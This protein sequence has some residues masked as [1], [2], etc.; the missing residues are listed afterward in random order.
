MALKVIGAG[1]GRTGTSSLKLA[2]EQLGFGKCYHATEVLQNPSCLPKW[3]AVLEGKPDWDDLFEGYQSSVDWPTAA[4]YKAQMSKYPEAKVI[5]TV[6]DADSW[7]RSVSET[8]YPLSRLM[9]PIWLGWLSERARQMRRLF[10]DA[11]WDG[12][13]HGR[14]EDKA[15]ATRIFNEHIE[16]VKREVRP[17]R[18]LV[19]DVREGWAPLCEFLEIP[20]IPDEPFP[21]VN[22]GAVLKG[23]LRRL[24]LLFGALYAVVALLLL[25]GV[26]A[27]FGLMS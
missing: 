12:V 1:F 23:Q 9:P 5:L 6:R 11:V 3:S 15:H 21:H 8:I 4:F 18:L 26:A 17:E 7:Y 2:L 16:A 27:L 13:F 14:F 24:R 25:W 20:D 19:F 22:E 10:F